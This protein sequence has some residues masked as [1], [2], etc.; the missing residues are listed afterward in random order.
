MPP[1]YVSRPFLR[2]AAL[3]LLAGLAAC[4]G[5]VAAP[6]VVQDLSSEQRSALHLGEISTDK[7]P[8]VAVTEEALNRI[9]MLVRNAIAEQS[10]DLLLPQNAAGGT[11]LR[12][13]ITQYDEGNAFARAMLAGLG[14]IHI[15]GDV[16]LVDRTTGATLAT[17]KVS[18]QFAFGG[19]LGAST[20]IEDVEKGFAKS[21]A[22]TV[23]P[24]K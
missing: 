6:T 24:R 7:Q 23:K 19:I 16:T 3:A 10:P 22:E 2:L 15:D 17:Y 12:I 11:A 21:V 1:R 18:K 20:S 13:L 9:T 4:A 5:S 8:S 14:Q